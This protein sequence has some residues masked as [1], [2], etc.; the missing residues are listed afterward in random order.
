VPFDGV[1]ADEQLRADLVI[2]QTVPGQPRDLGL[3]GR[4]LVT[5]PDSLFA[6]LFSGGDKLSRACSAKAC[7]GSLAEAIRRCVSQPRSVPADPIR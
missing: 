7:A 2:R 4:Q 5:G 1:R 3:L 6:N